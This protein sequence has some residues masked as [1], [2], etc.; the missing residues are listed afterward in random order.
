MSDKE[1]VMDAIQRLTKSATMTE[2][3]ERVEFLAAIKEGE[4]S[5]D[6]REGIPQEKVEKQFAA[7]VKKWR[8]KSSGR[9]RRSTISAA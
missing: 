7:W 9:N 3:R 5:L 4:D 2:I 1:Q 8:S 6:R